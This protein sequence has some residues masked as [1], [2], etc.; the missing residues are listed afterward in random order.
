MIGISDKT[1]LTPEKIADKT[2]GRNMGLLEG[3]SLWVT[4]AINSHS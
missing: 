2:N 3:D 1:T 4:G